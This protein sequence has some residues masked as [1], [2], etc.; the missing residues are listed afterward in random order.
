MKLPTPPF[1]SARL[2]NSAAINNLLISLSLS[3]SFLAFDHWNWCGLSVA[4]RGC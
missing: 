1:Y 2:S 4:D 3:A